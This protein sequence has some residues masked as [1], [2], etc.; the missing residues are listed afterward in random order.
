MVILATDLEKVD[1]ER[2]TDEVVGNLIHT[3]RRMGVPL[4]YAYDRKRL[5]CLAK[6]KDQRVSCVGVCNF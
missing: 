6:H 2:G 4:T 1:F 3:C 5:G